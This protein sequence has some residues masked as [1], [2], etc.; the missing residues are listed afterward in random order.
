ML[1]IK[2]VKRYEED[3]YEAIGFDIVLDGQKIGYASAMYE[4]GTDT[5]I[6]RI[7]IDED[8]RNHGYGTAALHVLADTF[9]GMIY[10]APDNEDAQ[11]LY[12]RLGWEYTGENADYVDQGFGVYEIH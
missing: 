3:S 7:D 2:E 10:L 8:Y 1:E 4:E 5:Y 12:D 9:G 11:R 6:D